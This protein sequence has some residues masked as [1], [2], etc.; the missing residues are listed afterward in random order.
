MQKAR[1]WWYFAKPGWWDAVIYAASVFAV[2]I[3]MLAFGWAMIVLIMA[4]AP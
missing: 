1:Q 4:W 3:L 2:A